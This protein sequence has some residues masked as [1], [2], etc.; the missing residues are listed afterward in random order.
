[1]GDAI[2]MY[3]AGEADANL[4]YATRFLTPDPYVFV[5]AGGRRMMAV[6]DLELG[7]ARKQATVD[8]VIALG[9]RPPAADETIA[10]ILR[11]RRAR[12]VVV[13]SSFPV[14]LADALRKRGVKVEP[15]A[16]VFW[17]A[18]QVK[19]PAEVRAIEAAQRAVEEAV[20]A[21]IGVLRR[22]RVRGSR[23]AHRGAIVT[24][25]SLRRTIDVALMER[26]CV[27][28]GTIVACGDDGCDPHLKGSGP[29]A[30]GRTI[31]MDVFPQSNETRYFAD[32]TRTVVK[33]KASPAVRKLYRAVQDAQEFGI[34]RVRAG[35]DGAAVH[36]EI[37]EF[38]KTAGWRTGPRRGR[39]EGF[40]HGTG[41]G[42]GLDIHEAPWVTTRGTALPEGAVVTVEPGLY[43]FG[44]GGVRLEDMV[45]VTRAGCRNLTRYPKFLEV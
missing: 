17:E 2:A 20:E 31:I 35:A 42:V 23:L 6:G 44:L 13:P 38:L 10:A 40:F 8:E 11:K 15:K 22:A 26:G 37:Q 43:Y 45:L 16:G 9:A 30:P 29:I 25:E 28:H 33:G 7:R 3:A 39:M 4:Y 36:R 34:S 41:H 5:Q 27:S 1:M 24:S 14:G 12:R 32:M 18:R 21:A 19:T